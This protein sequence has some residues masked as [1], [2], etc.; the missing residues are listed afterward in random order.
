[1]ADYYSQK[2]AENP[3]NV[4][5]ATSSLIEI[6][7]TTLPQENKDGADIFDK[8]CLQGTRVFEL[9]WFV[10]T[11]NQDGQRRHLLLL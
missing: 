9:G 11:Y 7:F 10:E 3:E 1:M 5:P 8:D 2:N 6:R 4:A